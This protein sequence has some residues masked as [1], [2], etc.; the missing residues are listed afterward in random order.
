MR[1]TSSPCRVTVCLV[2]LVVGL[3]VSG[4][5]STAPSS[6]AASTS[7][8]ATAT[9][10]AAGPGSSGASSTLA[11]G[12]ELS[13][14]SV[15]G[16]PP[17]SAPTGKITLC[18]AFPPAAL[19]AASG[20]SFTQT[21]ETDSDGVYGCEYQASADTY[22]WV[23]AVQEPS[24]GDTPTLDGLDLG[25]PNAVKPVGGTGYNTVASKAGVEMQFGT[26]VVEVYTPVT[27][28]AAQATTAQFVAVAKAMIAAISK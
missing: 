15:G 26:D 18:S 9:T 22:D 1:A 12:S 17:G 3:T 14:A 19:S 27:A 16:T 5:S 2:V 28:P 6:A 23:L 10:A 20:R 11:T 24:D 4:C 13:D 21:V 8:T 25:G 7:A